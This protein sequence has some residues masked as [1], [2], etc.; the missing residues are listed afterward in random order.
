MRSLDRDTAGFAG[1]SNVRA[2]GNDGRGSG[3]WLLGDR[4]QRVTYRDQG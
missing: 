4:D 3:K 1:A 2:A